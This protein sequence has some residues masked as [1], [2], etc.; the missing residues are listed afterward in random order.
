MKLNYSGLCSEITEKANEFK[1]FGK[2]EKEVAVW[3]K[4]IEK[5]LFELIAYVFALWTLKKSY[6]KKK[7]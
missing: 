3:R 7:I 6:I 1:Y 5:V 2:Y 4:N